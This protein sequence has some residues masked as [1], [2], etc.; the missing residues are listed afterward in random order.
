MQ[1]QDIIKISEKNIRYC[2]QK[3]KLVVI[4]TEIS[5]MKN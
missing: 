1:K 5:N 2:E 3:Y 4:Q